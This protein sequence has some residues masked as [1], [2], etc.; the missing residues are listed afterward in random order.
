[1]LVALLSMHFFRETLA[2]RYSIGLVSLSASVSALIAQNTGAE[3]VAMIHWSKPFVS[4]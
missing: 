4:V 2:N 3:S 1:M